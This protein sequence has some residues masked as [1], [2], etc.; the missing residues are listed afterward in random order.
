[1]ELLKEVFNAAAV[2]EGEMPGKS[3]AECGNYINL[4]VD[5]GKSVCKF[6]AD[7]IKD[8]SV[9]KLSY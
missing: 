7:V 9:E 8:W 5:I 2:F 4:D 6:Y 3:A 1:M